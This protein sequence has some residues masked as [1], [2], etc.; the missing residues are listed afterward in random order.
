MYYRLKEP[1]AFRGWKRL[2]YAI[3]AMT[4]PKLFEKPFFTNREVFLDMLYFN[5]Q[6]EVDPTTHSEAMKKVIRELLAPRYAGD[7]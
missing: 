2:P 4:G 3:C 6:E 5:G 1:Y 7:F